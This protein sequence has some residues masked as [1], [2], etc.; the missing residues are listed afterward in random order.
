MNRT[1]SSVLL[2]IAIGFMPLDSA[3]QLELFTRVEPF[4]GV[5]LG[6]SYDMSA[7]RPALAG[8]PCIDFDPQKVF[9]QPTRPPSDSMHEVISRKYELVKKMEL[10]AEAQLKAVTGSY[11]AGSKLELTGESQIH[12]YSETTMYWSYRM[13]DTP[14]LLSE[15]ITLKPEY[16]ALLTKGPE[17]RDEFRAKCG[18]GFV[19]GMPTGEY[20]Y[21]T[22][23][24]QD[25]KEETSQELK[26]DVSYS[27]KTSIDSSGY[28]KYR[29]AVRSQTQSSHKIAKASHTDNQL[30]NSNKPEVILQQWQDFKATGRGAQVVRALIAPYSVASNVPIGGVLSEDR[31]QTRLDK[32]LEALW[33]LK[34][35]TDE[36]SLVLREPKRFAMGFEGGKRQAR[37]DYIKAMVKSWTVEYDQLLELTKQCV[38]E[39]K[40]ECKATAD[41]YDTNPPIAQRDVLPRRYKSQC[42]KVEVRM[43]EELVPRPDDR[44]HAVDYQRTGAGDNEMGGGP[45]KVD[46]TLELWPDGGKRIKGKLRIKLE[47]LKA[48]HSTFL[49]DKDF[50]VFDLVEGFKGLGDPLEECRVPPTNWNPQLEPLVK[51]SNTYGLLGYTTEKNVQWATMSSNNGGLIKSLRCL[52]DGGGRD[53]KVRCNPVSLGIIHVR[54]VNV[55]DEEAEKW[56][57]PGPQRVVPRFPGRGV[58][59]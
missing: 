45:V 17:G 6:M 38:K 50:V 42:G 29:T 52:V 16:L 36:G 3:A 13:Q 43:A 1:G 31:D 47:E 34:T 46:A 51:N 33:D 53:D 28:A 30:P 56:S 39:F 12:Q 41:R 9:L 23:F 57:G 59:R 8:R 44:R 35:L 58:P 19:I 2:A 32:L 18:T 26:L 14:I 27:I 22:I 48:D 20:Y 15:H 54:L 37:H 7:Q 40:P 5:R 49:Y 55:L 10:T 25:V 11:S 4:D 21:A 24:T